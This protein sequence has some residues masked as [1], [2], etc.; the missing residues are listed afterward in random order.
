MKHYKIVFTLFYINIKIFSQYYDNS[1][2]QQKFESWL[3]SD[4]LSGSLIA[5]YIKDLSENKDLI[6][7]NENI[8]LQPASLNKLFTTAAALE[9]LKPDYRFKTEI[10]YTGYIKD[11]ILYGNIVIKGFGDPTLYSKHFKNYY[12]SIAPF[13]NTIE[14]LKKLN[15]KKIKGKII[16]DATY[17]SYN[18]HN[19]NWIIGD[20]GNYFGSPACAL[21]IFGNEY[22]LVFN[23]KKYSTPKLVAIKPDI[24]GINLIQEIKC[25]KINEDQ[26]FIMTNLFDTTQIITGEIPCGKDSFEVKG[27]IL[28]PPYFAAKF[29][30]KLFSENKII[31]ET[32]S[33]EVLINYTT[34]KKN[35][36]NYTLLHTIYSPPLKEIIKLTN[37]KS[38]NIFAENIGYVCA[39]ETF[40][41]A[42]YI[43]SVRS[44]AKILHSIT[45]NLYICDC[46]GLAK[47]NLVTAKQVNNLLEYEFKSKYKDVFFNSLAVAGKSGTM[48]KMFKNTKLE[49]KVIGKTGTLRNIRN[50]AGYILKDNKTYSYVIIVNN[51]PKNISDINDKI[52][53][54]FLKLF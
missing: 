45:D 16:A 6:R 31:V 42:D 28:N 43:H 21:S 54:L 44:I 33:I 2:I 40:G 24:I 32:D 23:T 7:Y 20:A 8:Y 27:A 12:D 48:Y 25:A 26:S 46:C 19:P 14:K 3:N 4:I 37:Q 50:I 9:I 29:L 11:T 38:I 35:S 52:I 49:G 41:I 22:S 36:I 18:I 10:G 39:K 1:V 30:K 13:N 51:C 15:I 5:V 34:D 17:F 53:E 47:C